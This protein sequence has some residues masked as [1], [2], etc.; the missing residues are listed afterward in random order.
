MSRLKICFLLAVLICSIII[1]GCDVKEKE[2]AFPQ[3]GR[4]LVFVVGYSPGG[5]TDG[6]VR[7]TAPFLSDELGIPVIVENIP[8]AGSLVALNEVHSRPADGYTIISTYGTDCPWTQKVLSEA[9]VP[10]TV[11]DWNTLGII[12]YV[13]SSGILVHKNSPW[14]TFPEFIEDARNRPGELKMAFLGPGRIDDLWAKDIQKQFGIDLNVIFY[15]SS[16]AIQTDLLTGDIDLGVVTCTREDFVDH[17]EFRVLILFGQ[18][19]PDDYPWRFPEMDAYEKELDYN[20]GDLTV[21]RNIN[22]GFQQV[23]IRADTPEFAKSVLYEAFERIAS[24]PEWQK[25]YGRFYWPTWI[26]PNEADDFYNE[27]HY[28]LIKEAFEIYFE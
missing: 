14:E 13:P 6:L 5:A 17:P 22:V 11:D 10:W 12:G 7:A 23:L 21:L 24:N 18:D 8:G 4:E 26:P 9:P 15:D 20:V 3:K 19:L 25:E 28:P 16:G 2:E 1:V 27:E